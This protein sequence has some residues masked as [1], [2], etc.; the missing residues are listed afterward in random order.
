MSRETETGF[1]ANGAPGCL[2]RRHSVSG[3]PAKFREKTFHS[4]PN[5]V[6]RG[7]IRFGNFLAAVSV[8]LDLNQKVQLGVAEEPLRDASMQEVPQHCV[9][10]HGFVVDQL[11]GSLSLLSPRRS[12]NRSFPTSPFEELAL[13]G[14]RNGKR[15]VRLT[16][17]DL[18]GAQDLQKNAQGLLGNICAR[19]VQLL[20]C[21]AANSAVKHG[22]KSHNHQHLDKL[23]FDCTSRQQFAKQL[24][25]GRTGLGGLQVG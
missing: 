16:F 25:R 22:N 9:T 7:R 2:F 8:Q 11:H 17:F 4:L 23:R 19:E 12:M 15:K 3:K 14:T 20:F 1:L 13:H 18:L 6:G 5:G 21:D 24:I 10:F